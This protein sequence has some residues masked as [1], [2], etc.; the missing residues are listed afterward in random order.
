MALSNKVIFACFLW[1][2]MEY[3]TANES[4]VTGPA[5]AEWSS[6]QSDI[7]VTATRVTARR[8]DTPAAIDSISR[9]EIAEGQLRIDLSESL[10]R[11]PG[12]VALNRQNYAQD[13]QI[14]SRGFGARASFGIRGVRVLVDDVPATIPDGQGQGAI[15]PLTAVDRI[16][17]LRGPN[18]AR[19]G[20]AAGGVVH[21][22]T[23]NP[24]VNST[25]ASIAA[26]AHSLSRV[27]VSLDWLASRADAPHG[28]ALVADVTHFETNGFRDHS[29]AKRGQ[30]FAKWIAGTAHGVLTL[31]VNVIEQPDSKDPLGL[32]PAEWSA[33]PRAAGAGAIFWNTRKSVS[34][35]QGA[36]VWDWE[37]NG[38]AAKVVGYGGTREVEQFLSLS[39]AA[40]SPAT[41]SGGVIDLDRRFGGLNLRLSSAPTIEPK[42]RWSIGADWDASQETR[43]GFENFVLDANAAL[44]PGVRGRLRRDEDNRT[45]ARAAYADAGGTFAKSFDWSAGLRWSDTHF[46]SADRYVEL[47]TNGD[48]SGA[49]SFRRTQPMAALLWRV[50][51]AGGLRVY[52]SAA[53]GFETPTA[54]ELAYRVLPDNSLGGFNPQLRA[55]VSNNIELGAKWRHARDGA[56]VSAELAWF[57]I[58][59]RDEVVPVLSAGGRNAFQNA[60]QTA[61]RGVEWSVDA[62]YG[63]WSYRLAATGL[64]AVYASPFTTNSVAAN[65]ATRRVVPAGNRLPGVPASTLFAEVGWQARIGGPLVKLDVTRRASMWADD[66]NTVAAPAAMVA[67]LRVVFESSAFGFARSQGRAPAKFLMRVDNL[68]DRQIVGSV[69]V[70]EA[71]GRFFE[72][73]PGRRL[74]FGV[75]VPF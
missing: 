16:E 65:V 71:N 15:I 59:S 8:A 17:V 26:G 27:G 7:V 43:R 18:A 41:S 51:D 40:Q 30:L 32:T 10:A 46:V 48:D 50:P 66:L 42:L 58:R 9:P 22:F 33:N 28:R 67:N 70:N 14:S 4:A 31:S 37:G 47:P 57:G 53:K 1:C 34:H 68:G 5:P 49:L 39:R 75:D 54:A 44:V 62:T 29:A 13:V 72:S 2:A 36:S 38:L 61:R 74:S 63:A 45:T 52:V 11:V 6:P 12:I 56:R 60:A 3:A 20:N 55:S 35:A 24:S 64:R 19:Y 23:R 73:A 25:V 69:I 21:A